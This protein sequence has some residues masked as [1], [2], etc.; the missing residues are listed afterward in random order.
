[1]PIIYFF[2]CTHCI[3]TSPADQDVTDMRLAIFNKLGMSL[4]RL[5]ILYHYVAVNNPKKQE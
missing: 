4:L 1:M 3:R 5:V 2:E